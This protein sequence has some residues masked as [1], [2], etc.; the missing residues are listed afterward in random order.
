[1]LRLATDAAGPAWATAAGHTDEDVYDR[2]AGNV[3]RQAL[4]TLDDAAMAE[5]VVS[6]VIVAECMRPAAVIRGQDAERRLAVSA[7]RRCMDL[8]DSLAWTSRVRAR[9]TTG[10][11]RLGA[12]TAKERGALGLVFFG[13]AGYRQAGVDLG[14]SASDMAVLLRSA[15]GQT[16][17]AKPDG[18]LYQE[19][20]WP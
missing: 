2:H 13:G 10:C 11:A 4:F 14:I 20:S 5:Q 6:D 9:R 1:M 8:A 15:I 3:Y 18:R 12:L 17:T 16:A 7:Y 19:R